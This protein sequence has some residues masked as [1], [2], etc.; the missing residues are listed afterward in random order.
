MGRK[1]TLLKHEQGI[2]IMVVAVFMLAVIG[3]M[4]AISIDVIT[5]YTARSEA[6]LAADGAALAGARVLANS[7]M[8][9]STSTTI[10]DNAVAL[11]SAIATQVAASN[12]VG[13]RNLNPGAGEVTVTFPNQRSPLLFGVNPQVTVQVQRTDL[14]TFFARIWGRTALTVKASAT[15]EAYNPSNITGTSATSKTPVAPTC[16]KPWLLPNLNPNPVPLAPTIFDVT[17]GNISDPNLLGLSSAPPAPGA[18]PPMSLAC[19]GGFCSPPP[20]GTLPN[21]SPWTYYPGLDDAA[22]FPHPTHSLP[23]CSTALNSYQESIA[24]CIEV[25]IACNATI[26]IDTSNDLNRDS[27]T[28]AAVNCLTRAT[29]NPVDAD[30]VDTPPPFQFLAGVNNPVPGAA[31]KNVMVSSSLVTVPVFEPSTSGTWQTTGNVQIVGFVQLFLNPDGLAAPVPAT[32]GSVNTT[33]INLV[34]CGPTATGQ[35]ILG[36]GASPVA[37]RLISQ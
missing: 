28:A 27:D 25:P 2:I 6:Q 23:T 13:G 36:N 15:A 19:T 14:P 1:R 30:R 34:G 37:V 21:P 17:T 26:N 22:D 3:A 12:Q 5:L 31:G 11:A 18:G 7:G 8:T 16:V 20:T 24:G 35:P 10:A 9:S 29:V 4:A 33:I 32:P